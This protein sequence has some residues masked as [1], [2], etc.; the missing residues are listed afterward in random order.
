MKLQLFG[1]HELSCL[2]RIMLRKALGGKHKTLKGKD[3]ALRGKHETLEISENNQTKQ[4]AFHQSKEHKETWRFE[5][6]LQLKLSLAGL[7]P[8]ATQHRF[9]VCFR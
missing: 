2:E 6:N 1:M 8:L 3:E 9:D 5:T 4:R 7:K